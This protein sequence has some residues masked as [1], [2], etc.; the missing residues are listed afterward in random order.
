MSTPNPNPEPR[1]LD[2]W[3]DAAEAYAAAVRTGANPA[4][5]VTEKA[6]LDM[7]RQVPAGPVLDAGC[8]E[9]WL[10]RE[11]SVNHEVLAMD[12]SGRMIELCEARGG[13]VEWAHLPFSVAADQPRRLLGAFGTVVFNFSL[14][15]QRITPILS[16]A[17]AILFPYGRILIQAAHPAAMLG[18]APEYRDG[19]RVMD[20]VAPGVKLMRP[21]PWYFR[22]FT[23]W[24]LELRR[25]GL[26]LVETLEPMD[27][28]TG[29]PASLL[30]HVTIPERRPRGKKGP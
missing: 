27:P 7:V 23:T 15:D 12:G 13:D 26:L 11:L 5:R 21:I 2:A 16:A 24:V 19:W 22:T 8:G 20:E 18:D 28:E 4:R 17:G 10:A 14:L 6:I 9:G 3:E 1:T 25:A 29:R 30:L